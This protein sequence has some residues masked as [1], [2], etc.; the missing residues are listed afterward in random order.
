MTNVLYIDIDS[1]RPDHLG[2][3][4]YA[5]DTSPVIDSVAREGIVFTGVH[6]S[7]TPCLPSRTALWS[8]RFGLVT[9]VV[10]HG[11]SVCEPRREG[12]T[13]G[14]AG[15][16][17]DASFT[18]VL[19]SLG[20]RCATISSFA[21]RHG[22]WHWLAGFDEIQSPGKR[23]LELASEVAP[24]AI[25]YIHRAKGGAPWFLHVNLW[26]PHTPYR[27]PD[28]FGDPFADA[29]L[30]G[31][32]TEA[33]ITAQVASFGPHSAAEPLGWGD[34]AK[35]P[36]GPAIID[37]LAAARAWFAGYDT[38]IR[39]ADHYVG[40]VLSELEVSGQADDTIVVISADHGENLGELNV[41]GDHQ[42]ADAPTC[43]IPLIIRWPGQPGF[44][45]RNDGLHYHFDWMAT[46]LDLL[47]ADLPGVWNARSFSGDLS[48]GGRDALILGQGAWSAQRG[49]RFR[50]DGADW[51]LL[52]TYDAG[53]KDLPPILLFNLTDDPAEQR[54]LSGLRPD[55]VGRGLSILDIW[56][57]EVM[58]AAGLVDDPLMTLIAEGGP[59]HV[60]G[61]L[62]AYAARL[63]ASGR[64]HHADRLEAEAA[65]FPHRR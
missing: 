6:A 42:T 17:L 31:W 32:L 49:V 18:G 22:A 4:G 8:G 41:W 11:G 29:A 60:Q 38:G 65:R 35:P 37:G 21:E 20:Y 45:G 51:L 16:Y 25:D 55:M 59:F 46:V 47:G 62:P 33:L 58:A 5:R 14:W 13:R 7:D 1:L 28:D 26:D 61:R 23:G 63:R 40:L 15:T 54:D 43:H 53:L 64:G 19:R 27:T 57:G 2:C 30:P 44:S 36:R 3:Y 10:G 12:A 52:R 34:E 9:G 50:G 48:N 24:R 39:Y 56:R